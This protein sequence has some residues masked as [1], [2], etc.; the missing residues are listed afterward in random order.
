MGFF[1]DFEPPPPPDEH[2]HETPVWLSAPDGWIGG[3]VPFQELIIRSEQAAIAVARI[4]AYPFG[5]ELTLDV[6]TRTVGRSWAFDPHLWEGGERPPEELLR[7]GVEF[8][9]GRK[10]S[11]I[12]G[13]VGGTTYAMSASADE[14]EPDPA[15]EIRLLPSS[16]HG[17]GRHSRQELWVWPLPSPGPLAFVCQWPKHGILESRVEVDAAEIR[18]ASERAA[19]LWPAA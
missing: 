5:F 14:E 15:G 13:M 12:G 10:A 9:D 19:E 16:G 4:V 6:F 8:A 7:Y 18:A 2:E 3:L 1:A 17:G 11:N